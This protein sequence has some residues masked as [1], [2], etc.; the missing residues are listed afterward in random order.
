MSHW[1]NDRNV[2]VYWCGS[3]VVTI[4]ARPK[5]SY[6]YGPYSRGRTN[7]NPAL[8]LVIVILISVQIQTCSRFKVGPLSRMWA[9]VFNSL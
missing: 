3:S 9:Y 4:Q 5:L 6:P 2:S 7:F 1:G 8:S